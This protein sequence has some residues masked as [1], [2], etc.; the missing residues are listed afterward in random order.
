[1]STVTHREAISTSLRRL[2]FIDLVVTIAHA[3]MWVLLDLVT[4]T[5]AVVTSL[6]RATAWLA[7]AHHSLAPVRE[8]MRRDD[9]DRDGRRLLAA[10]AA[11][12]G[13][14][15]RFGFAYLLCWVLGDALWLVLAFVGFPVQLPVGPAE[16]L[17]ATMLASSLVL[18]PL[19][20]EPVI[21]HT[22]SDLHTE[23]RR[24]LIEQRR[25]SDVAAP[26]I[27]RAM[28]GL[29]V[30]TF[31]ATLV[32][33]SGAALGRRVE[34]AR[35]AAIAE[36]RRLVE[37]SAIRADAGLGLPL[38]GVELVERDAL[39]AQLSAELE[40]QGE[41]ALLS[42]HDARHQQVFAAAP[43]ADGRWAVS[44]ARPDE[45]LGES[46][47]L[48]VGMV[49][50]FGPVF[51]IATWAY[52]RSIA[53]PIQRFAE[54]MERFASHGELR[55]LARTVP[56]RGSE[57]G[58]LSLSFNHMLDILEELAQAAETVAKG[59]LSVE[60]EREGELH[61]AF[62]GMLAQLNQIVG[63]MR[64]TSLEVASA[65]AEIQALTQQQQAA[66]EQQSSSMQQVSAT[67][68]SL[69]EAAQHIATVAQGV[70]DN[71]EQTVITTDAMTEKIAALRGHAATV[72]ALLENIREIADRSDL[73]ALN[74]SL[75]ATRAGEAGRGFALVAAEMRRLA[76]RVTQTVADV[77]AQLTDIEASGTNTVM[78]TEQSR[79]LAQL[80]AAAARQISTVTGQQ[81]A[82]TKQVALGVNELA[83]VIV[84]STS[85]VA[86]THAAAEGLRV[87][88]AELERLLASF[89]TADS[90]HA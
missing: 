32:G 85:A 1:M 78:A 80:T 79:K 66:T 5:I 26:T 2:L 36:Q 22:L 65:A 50:L 29:V 20:L 48:V 82:E 76:E 54:T 21:D 9:A 56:L 25:Q 3:G 40:R 27:T 49:I 38:E 55:A 75:E 17:A 6:L 88:A 34:G 39:P 72:S 24:A 67:V 73:L 64:E 77:R 68:V 37:V 89:R 23:I 16:L 90:T 81:S 43:L 62:R 44:N 12:E 42:T 60:L 14:G 10:H 31:V 47:G 52:A 4:P 71:A 45:G 7:Y 57:I 51:A 11:L 61:G 69:A 86:Q 46:L 74:G 87:H 35:G 8:W 59:D 15:R 58:R 28:T 41:R 13:F 30:A 70:L 19:L 33:L 53:Q 83:G 63:R 84:A 18:A